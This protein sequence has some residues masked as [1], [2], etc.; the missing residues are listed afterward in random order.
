MNRLGLLAYLKDKTWN[1][2]PRDRS[3]L[4]HFLPRGSTLER[5]GPSI[6][7]FQL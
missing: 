2:G 5:N 3:P 4:A 7:R 6:L 1:G